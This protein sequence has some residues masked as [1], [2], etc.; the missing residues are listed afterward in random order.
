MLISKAKDD[1]L[2]NKPDRETLNGDRK[3]LKTKRDWRRRARG[4]SEDKR[5]SFTV[6]GNSWGL[7]TASDVLTQDK[8]TRELGESV[9]SK[10][11]I[12]SYPGTVW[13]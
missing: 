8:G 2:R 1:N 4:Y 5:E 10:F 6:L 9:L 7:D 3:E 13:K 12:S 11:S